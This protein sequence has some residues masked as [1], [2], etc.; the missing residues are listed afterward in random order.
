MQ[1]VCS[2][3]GGTPLNVAG[4]FVAGCA[5]PFENHAAAAAA[6]WQ[7]VLWR[8]GG[9]GMYDKRQLL[10]L[11]MLAEVQNILQAPPLT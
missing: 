1:Y 6:K 11:H 10:T 9:V 3:S 5:R 7:Q 8:A 4:L 2:S